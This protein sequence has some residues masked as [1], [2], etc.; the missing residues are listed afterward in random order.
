MKSCSNKQT[1]VDRLKLQLYLV[2]N[3]WIKQEIT[4]TT[5]FFKIKWYDHLI[6]LNIYSRL[7]DY[8]QP[9]FQQMQQGIFGYTKQNSNAINWQFS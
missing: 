2:R 1:N 5:E 4:C 6:Y 7:E 8:R 9:S 3:N